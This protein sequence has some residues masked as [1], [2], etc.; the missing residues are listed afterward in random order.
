MR[1]NRSH[2]AGRAF[3]ATA[4]ALLACG[5]FLAAAEVA[6][7]WALGAL[8]AHRV[9]GPAALD[10]PTLRALYGDG[11]SA[12]IR[13]VLAATPRLAAT[14]YA[15]F[16]ESRT[17]PHAGAEP[18]VGAWG[19]R[20]NGA[21]PA[22]PARPGPKVFVFG[23]STTLGVGAGDAETIPAAVERALAAAGRNDVAVLNLA[24]ADFYSTPERIALDRLL[25]AGIVPDVAVFVDGLA[26]FYACWVPDR[27]GASDRLE[28]AGRPPRP[29]PLRDALRESNLGQ[30]ARHL[31]GDKRVM[32]GEWGRFCAGDADLDAVIHRLDTNRRII[33]AT[34]QSLG[35]KAVFVQQ[36][37]PVYGYDNRKRPVPV[38]EEMLGYHVNAA[39]GYPRLIQARAE[40]R[41]WEKGLVWLVDFEPESGVNAYV[42]PVHYSPRFNQAIGERIARALLDGGVLPPR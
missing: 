30:L 14:V 41:L 35:F 34:A 22:D 26:D 19:V 23:G 4:T 3:S 29:A 28:A 42:D 15:P 24:A 17:A 8:R 40:G 1:R 21:A 12:R 38:S 27:A 39:Q 9:S 20:G 33:A 11:D 2:P 16:T 36:P 10:D 37:V 7:G 18:Q 5:L 13:Q 6:A 32:I 31:A 25:T